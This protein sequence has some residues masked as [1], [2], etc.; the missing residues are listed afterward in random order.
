[1]LVCSLYKWKDVQ[2]AIPSFKPDLCHLIFC[3]CELGFLLQNSLVCCLFLTWY[4]Q[5]C[6]T[7]FLLGYFRMPF[8]RSDSTFYKW[9][10]GFLHVTQCLIQNQS[11]PLEGSLLVDCGQVP[12]GDV[13]SFKNSPFI[14]AF[15]YL[16]T[17]IMI[18]CLMIVF[19]HLISQRTLLRK[20]PPAPPFRGQS[21][22][23]PNCNTFL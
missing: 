21:I 7:S 22:A 6:F 2:D 4:S 12:Y 9:K 16:L 3:L 11:C 14:S 19:N 17:N 15:L 18:L 20:S 8:I 10:L 23:I 13:D 5:K 1:M